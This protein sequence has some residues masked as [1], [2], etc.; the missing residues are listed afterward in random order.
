MALTKTQIDY[1]TNRLDRIIN[2]KIR[3]YRKRIGD[4]KR[5]PELIKEGLEND[6]ITLKSKEEIAQM[7][8]EILNRNYGYLESIMISQLIQNS[9]YRS[10]CD[11]M[12][13]KTEMVN[14]YTKKLYEAKD[15][16]LD[17]FVLNLVD[18]ET[19]IKEFEEV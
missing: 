4:E 6:S 15:K 13:I 2:E 18:I 3:N 8:I 12:N 10:I 19:A 14:E 9:D 1:L 7:V 11:Q 17:K 16:A 5:L